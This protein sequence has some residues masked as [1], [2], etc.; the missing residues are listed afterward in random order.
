MKPLLNEKMKHRL[1]GLKNDFLE[2][3]DAPRQ[4]DS[5]G[6]TRHVD[7]TDLIIQVFFN[8]IGE[9]MVHMLCNILSILL[10]RSYLLRGFSFAP[11]PT[12]NWVGHDST[13]I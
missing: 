7:Q 1:R 4:P 3:H 10:Q 2:K 6:Q 11:Q 12:V 8:P 5:R 9:K 13:Q